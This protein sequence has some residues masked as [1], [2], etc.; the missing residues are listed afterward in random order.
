MKMA[1]TNEEQHALNVYLYNF[2]VIQKSFITIICRVLLG[3]VQYSFG[4]LDWCSRMKGFGWKSQV[5]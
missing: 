1:N 3:T 5:S 2:Y 4:W